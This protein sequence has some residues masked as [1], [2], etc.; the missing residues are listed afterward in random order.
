MCQVPHG[1]VYLN[2]SVNVYVCVCVCSLINVFGQSA[3]EGNGNKVQKQSK[4]RTQLKMYKKKEKL[5]APKDN[6]QTVKVLSIC[7]EEALT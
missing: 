5:L 7:C 3:L 1:R 6:N 2:L 4:H